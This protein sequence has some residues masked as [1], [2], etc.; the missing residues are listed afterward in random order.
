MFE[1]H[2]VQHQKSHEMLHLFAGNFCRTGREDDTGGFG[3]LCLSKW[4][5]PKRL[6][7]WWEWNLQQYL[8]HQAEMG[9][10]GDILVSMGYCWMHLV[11]WCQ[12]IHQICS[13][14][15]SFLF[16]GLLSMSSTA[17]KSKCFARNLW[18]IFSEQEWCVRKVFRPR[19][20]FFSDK[21][22]IGVRKKT[23]LW[24]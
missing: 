16:Q 6:Q 9:Q 10:I 3:R 1:C 4:A 18:S 24:T 22:G 13:P 2:C 17:A 19:Q 20:S 21:K 5:L 11:E 23:G 15:F 14:S 8:G 12:E 7:A